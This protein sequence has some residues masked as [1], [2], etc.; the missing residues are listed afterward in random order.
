MIPGIGGVLARNL[1]SYVG[2]VEGVFRE[3]MSKLTKIP[4]IG[5]VNAR[6][7]KES[8]VIHLAEEEMEFMSA[9]HIKS[10]FYLDGDYPKRLSRCTDAPIVF[11]YKGN[12][13][14]DTEKVISIVGNRN[15]T[16]DGR[17]MS[18]DLIM[19]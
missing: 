5:E 7:I 8:R 16:E 4:G 11:Y 19:E 6:R 18:D 17:Q 1:I 3:P 15:A 10:F 2:N 9:N 14:F 12:A 13:R